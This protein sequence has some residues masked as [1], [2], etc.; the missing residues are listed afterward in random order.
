[1]RDAA[2]VILKVIDAG[3]PGGRIYFPASFQNT[4]G[5]PLMQLVRAHYGD[6][7]FRKPPEELGSLV[8]LTTLKKEIG[9]EP[10][11][12]SQPDPTKRLPWTWRVRNRLFSL[13][14]LAWRQYVKRRVLGR[15]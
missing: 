4:Q 12:L 8:D 15:A 13:T 7:P 2:D 6:V 9:W 3:L 1:M 11:D 14:P 10:R 5:V